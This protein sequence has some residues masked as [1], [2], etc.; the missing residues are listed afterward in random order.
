MPYAP[1]QSSTAR[2]LTALT[3]MIAPGL[4]A[5]VQAAGIE[6]RALPPFELT[7][8]DGSTWPSSQAQGKVLVVNFWATWCTFCRE[9]LPALQ[10]YWQRHQKDGLQV[11][12]INV[13]AAA[14]DAK[15]RELAR[16]LE[17]PV[18]IG[19]DSK[20]RGFGR[21]WRLPM[22]YVVDASG[23]VRR[24]GSVGE[25]MIDLA[26]LERD[27]TPLLNAANNA[28]NNAAKAPPAHQNEK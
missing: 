7:L 11:V 12:T 3:L 27:V 28:A 20:I 10:A 5:Q 18:G 21:I 22:T 16:A 23:V 24:D 19:R 15:A 14:D 25:P 13:D 26:T 9:E 1:I 6:G 17:L 2:V 4:L 8:L